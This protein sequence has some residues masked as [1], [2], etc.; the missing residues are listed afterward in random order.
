MNKTEENDT[1]MLTESIISCGYT[2]SNGLGAGFLEKVYENAMVLELCKK[3]LSVESQ[4]AIDVYYRNQIVGEYYADILVERAVI[5]ELKVVKCIDSTHIAQTLNYLKA[6]NL[7][8]GIILNFK[9]PKLE[10][11]RVVL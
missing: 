1:N 3:G 2:V 7:H 6:C 11:K 8:C 9:N 4:K 5:I 10:I